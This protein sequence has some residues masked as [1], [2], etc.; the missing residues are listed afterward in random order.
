MEL[1]VL[2]VW[3]GIAAGI[4]FLALGL[5]LRRLNDSSPRHR[6]Y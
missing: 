5:A 3:W 1:V 4:A 2:L 6:R